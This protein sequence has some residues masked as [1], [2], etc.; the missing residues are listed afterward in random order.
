MGVSK[1]DN[2]IS[3]GLMEKESIIERL[4]QKIEN[5]YAMSE[6]EKAGLIGVFNSNAILTKSNFISLLAAQSTLFRS[7]EGIKAGEIIYASIKYLASLPFS[8][9]PQEVDVQAEGLSMKQLMR[10][11]SWAMPG[12]YAYIIEEGPDTREHTKSDHWRRIFQSL[13]SATDGGGPSNRE[14]DS[15]DQTYST[16]PESDGDEIFHD[17]LDVIYSTQEINDPRKGPLPRDWFRSVANALMAKNN[18]PSF[19]QFVIPIQRFAALVKCLLAL[20]FETSESVTDVSQFSNAAQSIATSFLEKP[21]DQSITWRMFEYGM[22]N[23]TPY[24]LDGYYRLL[25][26]TF[27]GKSSLIDVLD[28]ATVPPAPDNVALT[29]P[30][31]S[32]LVTFLAGS[33]AFESLTRMQHY[34]SSNLPTPVA[35]ISAIQEVPDEDLLLLFGKDTS[36]GVPHAFGIFSPKPKFDGLGIQNNVFPD[37]EGYERCALFQLAPVQDVYRGVVGK[38]GWVVDD[39][40]ITFGE[41]SGVVLTLR[42][43]LTRAEVKQQVAAGDDIQ[44]TYE[45]NSWRGNWVVSLDVS[46]IEIWSEMV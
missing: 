23:T 46:G 42:D 2:W 14:G 28:A 38:P 37:Q 18:I 44:K 27:L 40:S 32:Q 7:S 29:L 3:R 30:L 36:T 11:L 34:S 43:G 1:I 45:P 9:F 15:L 5:S 8:H 13:A 6:E 25:S 21:G 16:D 24:L 22:K 39:K 4:D 12:R 10:S 41:G 19:H 17:L 33:V 20:Q 31:Q 26:Q 35:L